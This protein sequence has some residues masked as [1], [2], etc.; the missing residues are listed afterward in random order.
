MP[1][2]KGVRELAEQ[3]LFPSGSRRN[4]DAYRDAVDWDGLVGDYDDRRL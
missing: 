2:L 1:V 3:D 4:Y